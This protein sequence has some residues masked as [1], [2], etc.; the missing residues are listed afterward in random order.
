[1]TVPAAVRWRR[2]FAVEF[3]TKPVM[4]V[5][6]RRLPPERSRRSN[7]PTWAPA[8]SYVRTLFAVL[9]SLLIACAASPHTA[10]S[11]PGAVATDPDKY[12]VVLEND[13]VRV[14]DYT[15]HP[16]DKTSRHHHPDFVLYA[17]SPF[18]RRL[19]LADGHVRVLTFRGGETIFMP[20]QD[21]G[22]ENVGT[23]DTHV[24]IIEL[25]PGQR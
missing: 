22:G 11:L 23:T 14:L 8:R 5:R 16:G 3:P 25:K 19:E 15:D 18:Q 21:H 17:L 10:A 1:M 12:R 24:L 4:A 20:A 2:T 6:E 7:L 13:R 9:I